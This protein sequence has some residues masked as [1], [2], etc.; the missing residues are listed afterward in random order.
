MGKKLDDSALDGVT[1]GMILDA[2][3]IPGSDPCSC[4]KI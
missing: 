2:S 4:V 3:K 1:G